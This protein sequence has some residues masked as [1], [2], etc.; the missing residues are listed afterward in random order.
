MSDSLNETSI[1]ANLQELVNAELK[2]D[3]TIQ[4]IDRPVPTFF[5]RDQLIF[6]GLGISL[7]AYYIFL[8]CTGANPMPDNPAVC[9][10]YAHSAIFLVGGLG[11][12]Y[13]PLWVYKIMKE[14]M[15]YALT[16]HRVI[17][18]QHPI[19]RSISLKDSV[20][21]CKQKANGMGYITF[22]VAGKIGLKFENIRNIGKVEQMLQNLKE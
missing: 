8:K 18:I 19:V 9:F 7:I 3:E 20:M 16:N 10:M 4:W 5:G 14:K 21:V 6:F 13:L 1:P 15:A 22:Y 11:A 12:L 17:I 2:D